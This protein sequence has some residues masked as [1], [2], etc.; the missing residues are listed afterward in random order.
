MRRAQFVRQLSLFLNRA[1]H[2]F[3]AVFEF[4]EVGQLFFDRADLDFIQIAGRFLA[5]ARDEGHSAALVEE[6]DRRDEALQR[7]VQ[8]LC[9]VKKNLQERG[10]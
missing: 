9:D 1:E 8:D 4:A 3:A 7:D 10:T 6:F 2:G 5:I